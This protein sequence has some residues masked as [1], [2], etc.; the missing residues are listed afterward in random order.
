MDTSH[1]LLRQKILDLLDEWEKDGLPS[2]YEIERAGQ[3]ILNWKHSRGIAGLWDRPPLMITATL[4]DALGQGLALIHL[5][6]EAAGVK[7]I[8]LGI[9]QS[10]DTIL[11]ECNRHH[12]Q[13]LGLTVLRLDAEEDL[14]Y[15]GHN[16]SPKTQLIAGGGSIFESYPEIAAD[17]RVHFVAK[18]A[19]AFLRFLLDFKAS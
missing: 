8:P 9:L 11:A 10:P 15:I 5:F 2:R 19:A 1:A 18:N 14:T 6:A 7:I 17:A 16:L 12:P 3:D 13:L 4:D